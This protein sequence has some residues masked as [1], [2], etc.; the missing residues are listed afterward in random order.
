MSLEMLHLS[1]SAKDDELELAPPMYEGLNIDNGLLSDILTNTN[2]DSTP[3]FNELDLII[4]GKQ[5]N[6]ENDWINLFDKH[7]NVESNNDLFDEDIFMNQ[8][9][10]PNPGLFDEGLLNDQVDVGVKKPQ[11]TQLFTPNPSSTLPT[12]LITTS[13]SYEGPTKK[14]KRSTTTSTTTTTKADACSP[15]KL[16]T[17]DPVAF[18]RARNTEAARRSRARKL[19]K[20]MQLE[21]RVDQLL[22]EKDLMS[23]EIQKLKNLLI[24]NNIEF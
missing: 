10:L 17:S 12:P 20:M 11:P 23:Q 1:P 7:E 24:E 21:D 13:K 14:R 9:I 8:D 3:M 16:E 2:E 5:V 19:E 22:K 6:G 18:K 15:V 4:D